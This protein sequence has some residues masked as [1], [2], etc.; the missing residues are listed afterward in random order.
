MAPVE[1][2]S[3]AIRSDLL[4]A[5]SLN[6]PI[7]IARDVN[8][9]CESVRRRFLVLENSDWFMMMEMRYAVMTKRLCPMISS[10]Q[11]GCLWA[12]MTCAVTAVC[13][14][15]TKSRRHSRVAEVSAAAWL[16]EV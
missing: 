3:T 14:Q 16:G 12:R 13:R 10:F 11:P 8:S 2:R 6:Y 1:I 9:G 4:E 7:L 5:R 15:D